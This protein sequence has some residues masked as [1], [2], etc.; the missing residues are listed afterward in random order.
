M[1]FNG[2][3]ELAL[4][5]DYLIATEDARFVPKLM[6]QKSFTKKINTKSIIEFRKLLL[7]IKIWRFNLKD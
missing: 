3:L 1:C 6:V 7:E 5:C 2:G 4:N